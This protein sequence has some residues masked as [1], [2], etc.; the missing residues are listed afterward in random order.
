MA[1]IFLCRALRNLHIFFLHQDDVAVLRDRLYYA[2]YPSH[3]TSSITPPTFPFPRVDVKAAPAV[4]PQ[5]RE[6]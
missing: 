3:V 1:V 6:I 2:Q 5:V 4:Q